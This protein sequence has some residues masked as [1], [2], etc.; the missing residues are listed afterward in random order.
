M[1][2]ISF[3]FG[4][5]GQLPAHEITPIDRKTILFRTPSC[6]WLP[7]DENLKVSII[8][9]ENNSVFYPIDFNYITRMSFQKQERKF[10]N[11]YLLRIYFSN[12]NNNQCL[13][14]LSRKYDE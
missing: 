5:Y 14:K 6:P 7:G 9:T 1:Y 3:D 12:K 4:R 8:I 2:N 10:I 13:L 11:I